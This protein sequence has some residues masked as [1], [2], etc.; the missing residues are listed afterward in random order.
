[1]RKTCLVALL[2]GAF[3]RAFGLENDLKVGDTWTYT[4]AETEY[5]TSLQKQFDGISRLSILDSATRND[6]AFYTVET[7]DSG[8]YQGESPGKPVD[9]IMT[10][11]DTI[12]WSGRRF[13]AINPN[14]QGILRP[15]IF[16]DYFYGLKMLRS[17][18]VYDGDTLSMDQN[19]G[20]EGSVR[21]LPR[22]G[23][24]M[25]SICYGCGGGTPNSSSRSLNLVSRNGEK[26]NRNW[27]FILDTAPISL[28]RPH[29]PSRIR[30]RNPGR[31]AHTLDGRAVPESGRYRDLAPGPF[32]M[33]F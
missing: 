5:R 18:V 31:E 20:F 6:T 21:W 29:I 17:T 8:R 13:V 32:R 24:I 1:M 22:W 30:P 28:A 12:A 27:L 10:R 4:L 33:A 11:T 26:F 3:A 2:A 19:Q 16:L 15:A 25:Q 14:S 9:T 7:L 23:V